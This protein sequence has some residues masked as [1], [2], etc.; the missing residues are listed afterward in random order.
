M[1]KTCYILSILTLVIFAMIFIQEKTHFI[2][3]QELNGV[4]Y[5]PKAPE[6][7]FENYSNGSL[8][9]SIEDYLRNNFGFREVFIRFYNQYNWDFYRKTVNETI[10]IGKDDWLFG[11]NDV[12]EFIKG[13]LCEYTSD[14]NETKNKLALEALRMHKVQTILS[15]Y[16]IFIFITLEPSKSQVFHE[17]LPN[18]ISYDHKPFHAIDFY[19]HAFDSLKINYIDLN[20]W[21]IEQ[22]DKAEYPLFP[23]A[24]LH[25]S[26]VAAVYAFD[27]IVKFVEHAGNMNLNNHKIGDTRP[28]EPSYPDNDLE[29][30][31]NLQRPMKNNQY[32]E[33]DTIIEK[34]PTAFWPRYLAVGDSYHWNIYLSAPIAY[35]FA[36][37]PYWYYNSSLFYHEKCKSLDEFDFLEELLKHKVINLSYSPVQLYVFSNSF[38]P[39][40]L[41][42]LCHDDE[43]IDS[44]LN[45]IAKTMGKA[46]EKENAEAAK[47]ALFSEPEKYFIDLD[48][49]DV[50]K[51]R[52]KRINDLIGNNK[53]QY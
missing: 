36:K 21:F 28:C 20:K 4:D 31:M 45:E 41:L 6:Y 53:K 49:N 50:P 34:D 25:W 13:G 14:T 27:T 42:Y 18:D 19:K 1:K 12:D 33:V 35:V 7:T 47:K 40:T 30:L 8:Q 10:V 16:N 24:G 46:T 23:K 39:K 48:S 17:F 44:T 29:K 11:A 22:K 26:N 5:K 9:E 15:E 32:F 52:N 37:F 2:K 38:L 3:L 43:E 51:H